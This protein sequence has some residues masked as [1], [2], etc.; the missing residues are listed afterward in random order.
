M[1]R[2]TAAV[3]GGNAYALNVNR[4]SLSDCELT[5]RTRASRGIVCRFD[6]STI[7]R[8]ARALTNLGKSK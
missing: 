1:R 7:S 4:V 2:E 3:V 8:R 5:R 6:E